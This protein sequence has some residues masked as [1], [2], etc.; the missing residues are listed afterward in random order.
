[1][2][3]QTD[4]RKKGHKKENNEENAKVLELKNYIISKIATA[5]DA[6]K[7]KE[8]KELIKIADKT[9][10]LLKEKGVTTTK[11]RK[12]FNEVRNIKPDD[13]EADNCFFKTVML[14]SKMAYAAGRFKE[15]KD[16][17][18]IMVLF[19]DNINGDTSKLKRFK[20]FFEAV[21]AYNRYYSEKE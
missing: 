16:F 15:L 10:E 12:I 14:K 20:Q 6:E 2:R 19:I 5:L 8:G 11:I 1:M 21:V 9:G 13:D 17:Y 4:F 7:D 18:E 3:Q